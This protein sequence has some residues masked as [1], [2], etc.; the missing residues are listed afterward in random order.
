MDVRLDDFSLEVQEEAGGRWYVVRGPAVERFAQM[1]NWDYY[2]AVRAC[3][4][5]CLRACVRA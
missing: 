1:T 2:E 4:P 3:T 5:H